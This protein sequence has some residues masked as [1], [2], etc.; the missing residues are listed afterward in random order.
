M[1]SKGKAGAKKAPEG[2]GSSMAKYMLATESEPAISSSY[3]LLQSTCQQ[4]GASIDRTSQNPKVKGSLAALR[5]L[6]SSLSSSLSALMASFPAV[7]DLIAACVTAGL[8]AR[9]QVA[10]L[11]ASLGASPVVE[12]LLCHSITAC[13]AFTGLFAAGIAVFAVCFTLSGLFFVLSAAL[14]LASGLLFSFSSFVAISGAT[15]VLPAILAT[16][17]VSLGIATVA[18]PHRAVEAG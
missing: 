15:M 1:S 12:S 3:A 16:G 17:V 18:V 10:A 5:E 11:C 14:A 8:L 13:V 9:S 4:I 7:K 6:L 2:S